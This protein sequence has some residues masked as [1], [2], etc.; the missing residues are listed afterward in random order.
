M[1]KEQH[2]KSIHCAICGASINP[3]TA[4]EAELSS[5][6]NEFY[7][8]GVP[9]SHTSQGFFDLGPECAKRCADYNVTNKNKHTM[10]TIKLTVGQ[11]VE[12]IGDK[13]ALGRKGNIVEIDEAKSRARVYWLL[14]PSGKTVQNSSN[15][16]GVRTWVTMRQL[17]PLP[18]PVDEKQ[19]RDNFVDW[20]T[21]RK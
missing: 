7:L 18:Q 2:K 6:D 19:A 3:A 20:R 14:E 21:L 15:G 16:I 4:K 5:T 1:N 17:K 10:T 8:N 9:E 12:R 11:G 13:S